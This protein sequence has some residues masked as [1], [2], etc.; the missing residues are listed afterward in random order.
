MGGVI[1][2]INQL[3]SVPKTLFVNFYYLPINV[4]IHLP[5]RISHKV[6]IASLGSRNSVKLLNKN[7][8]ISIG[9]EGS[10]SLGGVGYWSIGKD[11][12]VLF[13]G[14][15]V[16]GRGIQ[17]ICNGKMVIGDDFCCN[18]ECILNACSKIVF[19]DRVLL[20]WR[21][22]V[23]DGDGHNV[24]HAEKNEGY[25]KHNVEIGEHVWLAS[26]AKVL[27]G[28]RIPSGSVVAANACISKEFCEENLLIGGFNKIL[29]KNIIWER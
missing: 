12:S 27:K 26:D 18:A 1:K 25:E 10:F 17:F 11:A 6:K 4:A 2:K 19:G 29:R 15:A 13:C 7:A 28:S 14:K 24:L 21:S 23:L 8:R 5:I 3:L 9:F 20:G 22:C 16:F